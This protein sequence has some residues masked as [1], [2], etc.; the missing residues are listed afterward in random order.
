MQAPNG[1][2]HFYVFNQAVPGYFRCMMFKHVGI[3]RF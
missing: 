3:P 1:E 2:M